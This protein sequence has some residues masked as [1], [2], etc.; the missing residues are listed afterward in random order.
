MEQSE[1]H[2]SPPQQIPAPPDFPV[3]WENP[4]DEHLFWTHDAMHFPDPL[5]MLDY[6]VLIHVIF[7]HGFTRAAE[8]Y[9]MLIRPHPRRINT[10]HYVA[11]VPVTAPPEEMEAMEKRSQEKLETVMYQM[12]DLW[13]E[14]FLPEIKQHLEYWDGFDLHGASMPELLAHLD[15]TMNRLERLWEIHFQIVFPIVHLAPSMFEEFYQDL[16]GAEDAFDAYRL[17]Q[18]LG[19]KTVES[20]RMLW[21]LSRKALDV[22]EVRKILEEEAAADVPA[23]LERSADAREFF[24]EFRAY[25]DEYGHRGD[26]WGL[27]YPTWV[28]D[29]VPV[30][31]MLKDYVTRSSEGPDE[32]LAELAAERERLLNETYERLR[33]YP[34]AVREQFDSLL[35][36]AQDGMVLSE[37]HNFWI[38]FHAMSR[39][40][41]VFLEFGR[42]FAQA[43]ALER[44][45][46]V[47]HLTFD[48]LRETAEK[49]PDLGRRELVAQRKADIE[50]FRMIQPPPALGTPPPGPPPDDPMS[51]ALGKFFGAP[52]QPPCEP[53]MLQGSP[54]SPGLVRGPAR[55]LR[56]LSEAAGI[57]RGEVLVAETTAPPWTPLF[58]TAAAVVTDTGGILSHSAI[59]AR[60][61]GIPAVVGAGMAT[62]TIQDGQTVEVDGDKGIVRVVSSG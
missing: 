47:F 26:K 34:Q 18:G 45:D 61:Y 59:V 10:Y 50:H 29:P 42:R 19:N 31:K 21:R 6:D 62:T 58:A 9:E 55:V 54:G 7:R 38:D 43:G 24:A 20:G 5:T 25:L 15:E 2:S 60:E 56:S 13:R 35:E 48:E 49:L 37:D 41:R 51:R 52:P 23:A 22:P 28:E 3:V 39:V 36:A 32:D 12:G 53:G 46:D 27:S 4:D 30:I 33:G 57:Q 17:L 8:F 44:P 11:M 1:Q 14:E 40:R 16:F